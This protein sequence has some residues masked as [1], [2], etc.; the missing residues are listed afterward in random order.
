MSNY[1]GSQND[2]DNASALPL[3]VF[4]IAIGITFFMAFWN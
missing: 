2:P 4:I 1:P 3:A